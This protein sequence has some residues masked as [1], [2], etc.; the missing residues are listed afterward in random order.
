MSKTPLCV[1]FMEEQKSR[2]LCQGNIYSSIS[3]FGDFF[4]CLCLI[5]H[6]RLRSKTAWEQVCQTRVCIFSGT[7]GFLEAYCH[8]P[9]TSLAVWTTAS[10]LSERHPASGPS[11]TSLFLFCTHHKSLP[12]PPVCCTFWNCS[13]SCT[14]RRCPFLLQ[15]TCLAQQS[16]LTVANMEAT[17]RARGLGFW[18][19]SRS[20]TWI[21]DRIK[22]GGFLIPF[23][24]WN[25]AEASCCACACWSASLLLKGAFWSPLH[26][27]VELADRSHE[28]C[29]ERLG[30]YWHPT[31]AKALVWAQRWLDAGNSVGERG[32]TNAPRREHVSAGNVYLLNQQQI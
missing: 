20:I 2:V 3:G 12:V 18:Q 25:K 5:F 29:E 4:V 31:K 21:Q 11:L 14:E 13:S 22:Q 24:Q 26:P 10:E 1:H 9:E 6:L 19:S 8:I 17:K 32:A 30:D 28:F 16:A 23:P 7:S 27:N 15:S